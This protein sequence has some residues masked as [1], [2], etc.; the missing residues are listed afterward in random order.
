MHVQAKRYTLHAVVT[1]NIFLPRSFVVVAQGSLASCRIINNLVQEMLQVITVHTVYVSSLFGWQKKA[2]I[3]SDLFKTRALPL[4][5]CISFHLSQFY[6]YYFSCF[7]YISFTKLC[8]GNWWNS[9]F[10]TGAFS[11]SFF[12]SSLKNFVRGCKLRL[13]S[14]NVCYICPMGRIYLYNVD[15]E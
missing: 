6:S 5:S 15:S 1:Y 14:M 8:R 11:F 10:E 7:P 3:A 9:W 12:S 13:V 4:H 2:R